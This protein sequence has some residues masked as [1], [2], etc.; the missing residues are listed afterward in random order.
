M[1][2]R[3]VAFV[4][5]LLCSVTLGCAC[6]SQQ[7]MAEPWRDRL[8]AHGFYTLDFT[9]S[10]TELGLVSNGR[11]S[12]S[13]EDDSAALNNSL[14]GGQIEFQLN[15]NLS[16][17]LQGKV[18]FDQDD[19]TESAL[20]WAYLSYD[21]GNDV[22]VRG[23]RFQVPLLQ[24]TEL[25]SVTYSRL[26]ARPL[27]P[28]DGAGG[29]NE[30]TGLELIKHFQL[31][32]D[33]LH[34]Q[35]VAGKPSHEEEDGEIDSDSFELISGRYQGENYWL[36]AAALHGTY[37]V[38]GGDDEILN[39]S[40]E[41]FMASLESEFTLGSY[42]FNLGY[43]KSSSDITVNG[44]IYYFS[45]GL[46]MGNITP[47]VYGSLARQHFDNYD[48]PPPPGVDDGNGPALPDPAPA[49]PDPPPDDDRIRDGDYDINSIAIGAR[50]H[51]GE[52]YGFKIQLENIE[53]KNSAGVDTDDPA[54]DGNTLTILFEGVF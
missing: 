19:D 18:F 23:G 29:F 49:P 35:L 46:H 3:F 20:D 54:N 12:R 16:S 41:T 13:Y 47:F 22:I 9:Y 36:R 33:S 25:R 7:L 5:K 50:W 27:I 15:E 44:S 4:I 1:P 39:D 21:F 6:L 30:H 40:A 28:V 11:E 10:D 26:W 2:V 31:G 45:L 53:Q 38:R 8:H 34:M 32:F 37:S 14:I 43:A 24:G 48:E 52:G 17:F 42:I 51:V